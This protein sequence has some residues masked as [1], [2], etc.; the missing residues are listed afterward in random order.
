MGFLTFL[1]KG[2]NERAREIV[3]DSEQRINLFYD[4]LNNLRQREVLAKYFNFGRIK[5]GECLRNPAELD[6]VLEKIAV[7][8]SSDIVHLREEERLDDEILSDLRHLKASIPS[9]LSMVGQELDYKKD[10]ISMRN[11]FVTLEKTIRIE[12]ESIRLLRRMI[13]NNR[14]SI[15]DPLGHLF[16]LIFHDEPFLCKPFRG[17][18]LDNVDSTIKGLV[19]AFMS[20]ERFLKKEKEVDEEFVRLLVRKMQEDTPDRRMAE[21]IFGECLRIAGAPWRDRGE[22]EQGFKNFE[23]LIDNDAL[24]AEIVRKAIKRRKYTEGQISL[25]VK[26]FR[27]A[28]DEGHFETL[29]GE[30]YT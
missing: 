21:K 7:L 22:F 12:L 13:R 20:E 4:Y 2:N 23:R 8:L 29:M 17:R 18:T 15:A 6:G 11:Y 26:A 24:I 5:S 10:E 9:E 14:L 3:G 1:L 27:I 30:F 19:R 16:G 28:F 25:I